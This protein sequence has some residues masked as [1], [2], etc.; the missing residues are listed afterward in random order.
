VVLRPTR[1]K[2]ERRPLVVGSQGH[3]ILRRDSY[4]DRS[5][6]DPRGS[7]RGGVAIEAGGAV[8]AGLWD[9]GAGMMGAGP[10]TPGTLT[11]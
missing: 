9:G 7:P 3:A 2:P 4:T 1:I 8:V 11:G 5:S 6:N 10:P